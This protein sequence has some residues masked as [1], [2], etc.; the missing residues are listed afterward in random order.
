MGVLRILVWVSWEKEED[1]C[2]YETWYYVSIV[3]RQST[4]G[5]NKTNKKQKAKAN[6]PTT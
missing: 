1:L 3:E 5:K 2:S 4:S 6:D